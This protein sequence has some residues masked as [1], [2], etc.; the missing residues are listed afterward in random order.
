[1]LN[2]VAAARLLSASAFAFAAAGSLPSGS[3]WSILWTAPLLLLASLFIAWAAESAQFFIAQGFALAILAL[4]QTFPEFAVEAVL[5]WH[6]QTPLLLSNMTG[7]LR[8]LTGVGWPLIYGTAAVYH[9][10]RRNVPLRE[11]CLERHDSIPV[12]TLL[13][14]L[15][16]IAVVF[17]KGSLGIFDAAILI[18]VYGAYL[19]LLNRIPPETEES[20]ENLD[21]VSRAV[22]TAR[23]G[24]RNFVIATLFLVGGG[25][26][27]VVAEPFLGSLLAVS[28]AAG[29]SQFVAVQWIAP[30]V[31]E[32]PEKVSAFFWARTIDRA[33]MALMNMVSSNINQW[34][35]L[36]AMLPIVLS[37]GAGSVSTIYLDH[38]QSLEL[39][40]TIAQSLLGA[41]IL[42]DLKLT[43]WEAGLL[44]VL[45]AVQFGF[46]ILPAGQVLRIHLAV[47]FS[48]L[49]WC[50]VE[51]IRLIVKGK[52]PVA[53]TNFGNLVRMA[54][55]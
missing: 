24:I 48:Y 14:S 21:I 51:I 37:L 27:F 44:F 53:F 11:I 43:W 2:G 35:L 46:S 26:I 54:K 34:T 39:F 1:M 3:A 18:G 32:F 31:S 20:T 40:M 4:L 42:L 8:L 50:A 29:I 23:P 10:A 17:A 30:F 5:A 19:W 13:G 38:Q 52:V 28:A 25:L 9:R 41:L 45:W 22:V 47:T 36:A 16:W 7:A 33:P 55:S 6:Q 12:V 49:A 15:V